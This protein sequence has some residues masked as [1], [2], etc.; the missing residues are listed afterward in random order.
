MPALVAAT[1]LAFVL[2]YAEIAFLL[3][4]LVT[5][6]TKVFVAYRVVLGVVVIAL[7]AAGAIA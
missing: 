4:L 3:R 1:A 6:T 2:G 7:A 5:H